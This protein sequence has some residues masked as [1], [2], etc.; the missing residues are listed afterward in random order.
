MFPCLTTRKIDMFS[1]DFPD[2][3]VDC[4][5]HQGL[6]EHFS[7]DEIIASLKEQGRVS[8]L[9][10][11]D[12]PNDRRLKKIQEFGNERFISVSKWLELIERAGL[13]AFS[14]TGRRLPKPLEFLNGSEFARKIFGTSSIF[15]CES[16]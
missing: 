6:L 1:I 2:D 3:S 15:V 7:D 8:E 13:K 14:V 9:V 16:R 12:V 10:I 11:F 5:F 4:I